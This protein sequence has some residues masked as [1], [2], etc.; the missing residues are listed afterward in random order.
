MSTVLLT[1]VP[2]YSFATALVAINPPICQD[3]YCPRCAFR[4]Q[5]VRWFYSVDDEGRRVYSCLNC[6]YGVRDK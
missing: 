3:I 6:N 1:G 2:E 5:K 4:N